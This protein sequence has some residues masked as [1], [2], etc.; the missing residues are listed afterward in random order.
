[1]FP[2]E[3]LKHG[4]AKPTVRFST[5]ATDH[6]QF[7][8]VLTA[9]Y[10]NIPRKMT[11]RQGFP[12]MD[13]AKENRGEKKKKQNHGTIRA[14][15][16]FPML[17]RVCLGVEFRCS[18]DRTMMLGC[19]RIFLGQVKAETTNLTKLTRSSLHRFILVISICRNSGRWQK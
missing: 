4:Y 18:R 3:H 11:Q 17:R 5:I 14:I 9:Y 2:W 19:S 13:V 16:H 15:S 1:M 7:Y 6:S 10:L 12:K 8:L